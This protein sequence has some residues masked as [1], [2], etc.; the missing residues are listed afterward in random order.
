MESREEAVLFFS[1]WRLSEEQGITRFMRNVH[2][3]LWIWL[4]SGLQAHQTAEEL[5][6][7][8]RSS[9]FAPGGSS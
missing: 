6:F 9:S 2:E 7:M 5:E 8:S 1:R 4:Q 3:N